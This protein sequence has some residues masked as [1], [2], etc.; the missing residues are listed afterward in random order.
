VTFLFAAALAI[1][2]FIG[3]PVLAH[4]LRRGRAKDTPFAATHLVP[5]ERPVA[6]RRGRLE[7]RWL[8]LLRG[9]LILG[10]ALLGATP[11]VRCSDLTLARDSGASI[12]LAIVLDDSL[13]M[14]AKVEGRSR[15]E[16]AVESARQLLDDT[17]EGDAVALVL[18]GKPARLALA[19]TT[20]IDALRRALDEVHA[21][22]LATELGNS[23]KLA[24]SALAGLPHADKRV[25][26]LSDLAADETLDEELWA[27][28]PELQKPLFDCAV[29]SAERRG[30][31]VEAT[32]ACSSEAAARRRSVELVDAEERK[33]ALSSSKPLA[34]AALGVLV[35]VQKLRFEL[36]SEARDVEVKL[37]GSDD[38]AED[39]VA[40]V[41]PESGKRAIAVLADSPSSHVATG[42]ASVVEQAILAL[43]LD[44]PLRPLTLLPDDPK[45]YAQFALLVVDDPLGFTPETRSVLVD[46]IHQGGTA[47]A[48]LGPR[49]ERMPLGSSLLPFAHGA[50]RWQKSP[51]KGLN[52]ASLAWFSAADLTDL[53]PHGR[54]ELEAAEIAGSRVVARWTDDKPFVVARDEGK[55][56]IY[57]VALPA[58]VEES[59]LSLRPGFLTL[60]DYVTRQAL[61]R[62]GEGTSVAGV[63]WTFSDGSVAITGPR[64]ALRLNA[65]GA[66]GLE[67]VA[68]PTLHGRYTLRSNDR[69]EERIVCLDPQEI[70]AKTT[71]HS[72]RTAARAGRAESP[73][74]DA[75]PKLAFVLL[76]LLGA[77][78]LTR[79]GSRVRRRWVVRRESQH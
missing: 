5:V 77:E 29:T 60:L 16:R 75:S 21:S 50:L 33:S 71:P 38:I 35:G 39:D 36:P 31:S 9:L 44:A 3:L 48:L 61:Q 46:W 47:L 1:V 4:F 32:V 18:A 43:E 25:V 58:S 22:D 30:R 64:G 62:L 11:L 69:S 14:R 23:L 13:S 72:S 6:R 7:D 42:G 73:W 20:D 57:T 78:V 17:R 12:A 70:L 37:S 51:A 63:P 2:G 56:V 15:F 67:F 55:G 26:V 59:D 41:A 68:L 79:L 49:V 65:P 66:A 27:P 40:P 34:S 53:A 28:N 45:L 10:L 52:P 8:L 76:A 19:A 54:V 74:F 24:R